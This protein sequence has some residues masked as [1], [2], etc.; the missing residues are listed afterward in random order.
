MREL[1][2]IPTPQTRA[3]RAYLCGWARGWHLPARLS[4]W[5]WA[6]AHRQLPRETSKE[7]GRWRTD[8]NP[9]AKAI[10]ESLSPHSGAEIVTVVAGVQ[11]VKTESLNNL[12]GYVLDHDPGPLI[13]CQP[14]QELAN[15]WKLMRF[16][17]LVESTPAIAAKISKTKRRESSN[18]MTRVKFPGG[19]LIVS[20]AASA[21]SLGMYSARWVLADEVDSYEELKGGEGDPLIT[22]RRRA[23]SFG[24]LRKI[25]QCSSP[26]KLMGASLIWREYLLGDQREYWVP[27]P[28]CDAFQVLAMEQILPTGDYLC[29]DCGQAIPHAAK[30]DLLARGEWRAK[31]PTRTDHHSYRLPS[32]Y[33]PLGLG[34][35]WKELYDERLAAGDDPALLKAFVSTSLAIPYEPPGGLESD[36]LKGMAE[37]WPQ[38]APPKDCLLLV[39]AT[40]VQNDRLETLIL[41]IGRGATPKAPQLYVVDY[42]VTHGSPI[43]P[44]TFA[45]LETYLEDPILN[46]YGVPLPIRLHAVD[47]G[48]WANEVYLACHQRLTLGW[49]PIKGASTA[50]APLIGGPKPHDLN[51]HG[52]PIKHG[53]A[54]HLIG[55]HHAKD[56]LLD[57]LVIAPSQPRAERWWHLPSDLPDAWYAGMTSERRDPETHRWEK[58]KHNSRNEAIDTAVYAWA[59]CHLTGSPRLGASRVIR[60]QSKTQKDWDQLQELMC[61]V[62]ADLFSPPTERVRPPAPRPPPVARLP[63]PVASAFGKPGWNL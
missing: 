55:T 54:H 45:D 23:D 15:A 39:A 58:I 63:P 16:D 5:Q 57:R 9:P 6:D 8:R 24:R 21:A 20:H 61:P 7:P 35:T 60:L 25:Y 48:N 56:T 36:D 46:P 40:D 29:E 26:K 31:Y 11:T 34:R 1:P 12:A 14:T 3:R 33:T 2:L 17:A 27:C 59:I 37:D 43:D 49:L 18:T 47:S 22:L 19:W 62:Q 50:A 10:M 41:G 28:H 51:W 13:I 44:A 38:R 4:V 30:T 42:H 32:L 53:G 52:R